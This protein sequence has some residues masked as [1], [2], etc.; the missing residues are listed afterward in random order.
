MSQFMSLDADS[1]SPQR[2]SFKVVRAFKALDD[3]KRRKW[4]LVVRLQDLPSTFPLDANARVPNV[5][6]NK[7]CSEMRATLLTQ[8]D[9]FQVFNGGV[10]C[11]AESL[12]VKQIEGSMHAEI[13]FDSRGLQGIVNGGHSYAAALHVGH[14]VTS[15]SDGKDLAAVLADDT[16]KGFG[17]VRNLVENA[18]LLTE[19]ISKARQDACIQIEV[20]APVPNAEL[21]EQIARARNLSQSV[22]ETDLARLAGKLDH[23]KKVLGA[24]FGPVFAESVVWKTNQEVPEGSR[25]IPV[26]LLLQIMALMNVRTYAPGLRVANEV[27]S[28]ASVIIREFTEAE[29][30][31]QKFYQHLVS[32]LPA[33]LELYD[34]VYLAVAESDPQYPWATGKLGEDVHHHKGFTPIF[35]RPCASRVA[36]AFVWPIF[37]ALRTLLCQPDGSGTLWFRLDPIDLFKEKRQELIEVV[38]SFHKNQAHGIIQQVGKDKELWV[39]LETAIDLELQLRK[40]LGTLGE[41]VP[42]KPKKAYRP[43]EPDDGG[44]DTGPETYTGHKPRSCTFLN[45]PVPCSAWKDIYT[46]VAAILVRRHPDFETRAQELHGTVRP[47]FSKFPNGM[48]CPCRIGG[49]SIYMETRFSA[50]DTMKHANKLLAHFGYAQEDLMVEKTR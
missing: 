3:G 7:T 28:R 35:A 24:A 44:T 31:L 33:V 20:V 4:V 29:G 8:P 43:V 26:K 34:D 6:K 18:Q 48:S 32:A 41:P 1:P 39:R 2:I 37:A 42:C 30:E 16:R 9:L 5:L 19:R 38:K 21:L 40:R 13:A 47:Y 27:Y 15:Y 17:E 10:V 49:T 11:T 45:Q 12:E 46:G 22:E 25:K 14:G 50:E 36:N 23:M